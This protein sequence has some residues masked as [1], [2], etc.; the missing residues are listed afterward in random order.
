MDTQIMNIH[1]TRRPDIGWVSI[2]Q[3]VLNHPHLSAPAL[4]ILCY[5]LGK[6]DDWVVRDVQ[7][8]KR[9]G[10]GRDKLRNIM[11][12]LSSFGF[13]RISQQRWKGRRQN[14]WGA[15]FYVIYDE[16]Q[17]VSVDAFSVDGKTAA[18]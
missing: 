13:V 12:E 4:G 17:M 3:S 16:P 9:F 7:L 6:P 10:Y 1:R 14:L 18:Y 8:R 5:V 11:R 2:S 15:N